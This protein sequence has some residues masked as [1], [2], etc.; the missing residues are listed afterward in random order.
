M[1]FCVHYIGERRFIE[2]EENADVVLIFLIQFSLI[3][4]LEKLIF[5]FRS[6]LHFFTSMYVVKKVLNFYRNFG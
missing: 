2:N 1:V 4:L 6:L 5:Y 3:M